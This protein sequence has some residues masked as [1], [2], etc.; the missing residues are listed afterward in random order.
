MSQNKMQLVE[1]LQPARNLSH[2]P[3]FQTGFALQN[4]PAP[5]LELTGVDASPQDIQWSIYNWRQ[6]NA[7]FFVWFD[8]ENI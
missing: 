8:Q 6:E 5:T 4:I 7:G 3:L 1:E 2:N